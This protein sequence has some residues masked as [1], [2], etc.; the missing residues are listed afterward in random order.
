MPNSRSQPPRTKSVPPLRLLGATFRRIVDALDGGQVPYVVI[1]A[2]AVRAYLPDR[3][4]KDID[5]LVS[6]AEI[7]RVI[8]LAGDDFEHEGTRQWGVH[9]LRDRRTGIEVH[10]RAAREKSDRQALESAITIRLFSRR[11]RIPAPEYLVVMKLTS[12][13]GQRKHWEDVIALVQA[14]CIDARFVIAHLVR[15]HPGLVDL[16]IE[17][18]TEA[19]P[20]ARARTQN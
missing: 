5:L 18:V 2:L 3:A 19:T 10:V 6:L 4:T 7:E 16:F 8:A 1:G 20:K 13:R 15:Q 9:V 17:L 14:D 12:M 11:V